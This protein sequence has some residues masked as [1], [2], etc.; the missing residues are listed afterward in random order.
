[1]ADIG[2]KANRDVLAQKEQKVAEL[3]EKIKKAK[4]V[5]LV[6]YSGI[7][8]AEDTAL[9]A[10]MRKNGVEYKVVKNTALSRAFS[11]AGFD[12]LDQYLE[13]TTAV[14]FSY[15]DAVAGAK[16]TADTIAK[17]KKLAF[18]GGI[19]EGEVAD[20]KKVEALSKIPPKP[21]LLSQLLGLLTS[22]MRSLA[23]AIA[24]VAKKKEAA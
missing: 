17:I 11:S 23:V 9:R 3:V 6:D 19:I 14:A 4:S 24:E 10:E 12:G 13:K 1:M 18:K 8:V 2:C 15:E 20:E 5:I 22:P 16:V 7:T 21:V